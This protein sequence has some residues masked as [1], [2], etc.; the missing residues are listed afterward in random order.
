MFSNDNNPQAGVSMLMDIMKGNDPHGGTKTNCLHPD[1]VFL[2]IYSTFIQMVNRA[3]TTDVHE[4]DSY[5]FGFC[6]LGRTATNLKGKF[7]DTKSWLND[8]ELQTLSAPLSSR[9]LVFT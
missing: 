4:S 7:R 3:L 9:N 1:R 2:D 5:L 8:M 6:N